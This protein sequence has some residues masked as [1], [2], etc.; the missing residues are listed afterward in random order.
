MTPVQPE[1][2]SALIDG[3]LDPQRADEVE[4]QIAADPHLRAT[5][6]TLRDLDERWRTAARTGAL[7]PRVSLPAPAFWKGWAWVLVV[8]A[9]LAGVRVAV[10][11]VDTTTIAYALQG[12]V[13]VFVLAGIAWLGRSEMRPAPV[14]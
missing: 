10:R 11:L 14:A 12:L 2:L 4:S 9:A 8:A 5:F 13:L 7:A 6:E 3:E 1:E